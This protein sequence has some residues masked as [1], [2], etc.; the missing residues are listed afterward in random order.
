[1]KRITSLLMATAVLTSLSGCCCLA[2]WF[3]GCGTGCNTG[4]NN[5]CAPGF[6]GQPIIQ[7]GATY[8]SYD[9]ITGLPVQNATAYQPV[10]GAPV[11][12]LGPLEAL[13]TYR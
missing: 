8:Q 5:G 2:P 3:G 11:V 13:P 4:C 6:G 9:S 10:V 1:M 7:P 12:S